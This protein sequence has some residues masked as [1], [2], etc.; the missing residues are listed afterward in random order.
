LIFAGTAAILIGMRLSQHKVIPPPPK[1]EKLQVVVLNVQQGEASFVRTPDG[2]FIVIGAGPPDQG[3]RLVAAL[4]AAGAKH[5]D[6]ICLPYPGVE[7]IGGVQE[8]LD[9]F[10]VDTVI[11]SG[12]P[13]VNRWQSQVRTYCS[14]HN[15][16]VREGHVGQMILVGKTN[17][18]KISVAAPGTERIMATPSAA[19]NSLVLRLRYGKTAFVWAGGLERA[20]EEALLSRTPD[21][22]ANWLR[23]AHFG[24]ANASSSEFLQLVSPDY[25]V[26]SVG[27]NSSG[28]PAQD[29]L[30]RLQAV[31]ATVYRTDAAPGSLTF[32]SDGTQVT[33]PQSP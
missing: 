19:N 32:Y 33:A 8:L 23:V 1:V 26:I 20:G 25:A 5:L 14:Q 13:V 27:P 16:T 28:L 10:T 24:S 22:A 29:T 2:H 15:I 9:H 31:G 17:Q 12:G 21:L 30:T 3:S 18:I 6:L 7:A 11:D 4:D